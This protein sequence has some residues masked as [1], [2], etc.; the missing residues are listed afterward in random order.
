MLDERGWTQSELARRTNIP[1]PVI[2]KYLGG[3]DSYSL[4]TLRRLGEALDVALLVT[5]VPF[6]EFIARLDSKSY[7]DLA[8]PPAERDVLLQTK[9]SAIAD[10]SATLPVNLGTTF[11]PHQSILLGDTPDPKVIRMDDYRSSSHGSRGGTAVTQEI[12][13]A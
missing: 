1:Q 9:A 8:V 13:H 11:V 12:A 5:Y 2:S 4:S 7:G 3:Y 10:T 6:S